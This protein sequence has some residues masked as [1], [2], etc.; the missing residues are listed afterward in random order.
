MKKTFSKILLITNAFG[1]AFGFSQVRASEPDPKNMTPY[2]RENAQPLNWTSIAS[3]NSQVTYVGEN[4][5][6]AN[7]KLELAARMQEIR[8][9]GIT[10]FGIE[11]LDDEVQVLLDA[12]MKDGSRRA[13]IQALVHNDGWGTENYMKVFDAARA[14][15]LRLVS[16]NLPYDPHYSIDENVYYR[17]QEKANSKYPCTMKQSVCIIWDCWMASIINQEVIENPKAKFLVLIGSAHTSKGMQ[18]KYLSEYGITSHS[19]NFVLPRGTTE[20]FNA[21]I[22]RAIAEIGFAEKPI[23]FKTSAAQ[24]LVDGFI[25]VP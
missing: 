3:H 15:G 10:H 25:Y 4:H 22:N 8:N 13:E 7:T 11:V 16:L 12:F 2:I 20:P 23:F 6:A 14:A 18:P 5:Y 19:F 21:E 1:F 9:A 17:C 24:L